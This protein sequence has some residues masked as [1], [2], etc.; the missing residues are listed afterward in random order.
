MCGRTEYRP[1]KQLTSQRGVGVTGA[2][3]DVCVCGGVA[4]GE[5]SE[6]RAGFDLGATPSTGGKGSLLVQVA[7]ATCGFQRVDVRLVG[8]QV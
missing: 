5:G 1:R 2:L 6:Q 7:A 3:R 8:R 4:A